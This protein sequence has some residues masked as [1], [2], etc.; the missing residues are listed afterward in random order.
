MQQV[1]EA[2]EIQDEERSPIAI[3]DGHTWVNP[4]AWA[5]PTAEKTRQ[6]ITWLR[7]VMSAST[8]PRSQHI[9]R[10]AAPTE[11]QESALDHICRIDPYLYIRALSG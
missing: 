11:Q 2:P 1:L 9:P 10:Y 4:Q 3:E 8:R 7:S 5:A 6:P